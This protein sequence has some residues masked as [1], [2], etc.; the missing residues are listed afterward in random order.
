MLTEMKLKSG[1]YVSRFSFSA[2]KGAAIILV[3]VLNERCS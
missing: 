2:Y 1:Y 3:K